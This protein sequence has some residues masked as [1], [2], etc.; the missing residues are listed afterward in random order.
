[1]IIFLFLVINILFVWV[2]FLTDKNVK[3][4]K[5]IFYLLEDNNKLIKEIFGKEL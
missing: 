2:L 1:M 4:E 3:Q 5:E